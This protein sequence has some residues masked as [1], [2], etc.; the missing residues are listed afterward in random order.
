MSG[1]TIE[2][3]GT[4]ALW[5]KKLD[6]LACPLTDDATEFVRP[7]RRTV[8]GE[9]YGVRDMS[10]GPTVTP[11]LPLVKLLRECEIFRPRGG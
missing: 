4:A 9:P 1:T 7:R 8:C 6:V 10:G 11:E 3:D 5:L 2:K